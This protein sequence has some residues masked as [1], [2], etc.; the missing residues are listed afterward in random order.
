MV[1]KCFKQTIT[2]MIKK[3]KGIKSGHELPATQVWLRTVE[4]GL[5][6]HEK[7]VWG[8]DDGVEN[9]SIPLLKRVRTAMSDRATFSNF[10]GAESEFSGEKRNG[11]NDT[12]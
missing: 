12:A 4:S 5:E 6:G 11:K 7:G 8:V 9:A 3:Q 2:K 1:W 10:T